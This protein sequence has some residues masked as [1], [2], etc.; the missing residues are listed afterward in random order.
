MSLLKGGWPS[1]RTRGRIATVT[2]TVGFVAATIVGAMCTP[3]A[4]HRRTRCRALLERSVELRIRAAEPKAAI[5][6]V[7]RRKAEALVV[8]ERDGSLARCEASL[9]RE[10]AECAEHAPTADAFERCFP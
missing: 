3:K 10:S 7:E 8:A 1:P 2:V 5:P 6:D 4:E 9:G